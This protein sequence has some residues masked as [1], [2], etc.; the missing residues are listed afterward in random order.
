MSIGS[1]DEITNEE[2]LQVLK[3]L[4]ISTSYKVRISED[5]AKYLKLR[6]TVLKTFNDK[7]RE[8]VILP[9]KE[10]CKQIPSKHFDWLQMI[11]SQ[12]LNDSQ[13]TLEDNI[14]VVNPELLAGMYKLF[15]E[16]EDT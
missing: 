3:S 6:N 8:F 13:K 10:L 14:L 15:I 1:V 2:T 16:L 7:A 4:N 9:I 12:L 5:E 11:N